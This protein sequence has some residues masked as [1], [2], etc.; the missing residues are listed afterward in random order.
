[1]FFQKLNLQDGVGYTLRLMQKNG[2]ITVGFTPDAIANAVPAIVTG[3][4]EELDEKLAD[5]LHAPVEMANV[6]VANLQQ[7]E[8][9]LKTKSQLPKPATEKLT[10][11]SKPKSEAKKETAEK[12]APDDTENK[13]F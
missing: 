6:A 2:R 8:E 9:S 12:S 11:S 13:L 1:M 4:A 10:A 5:E 3:T 7:Y